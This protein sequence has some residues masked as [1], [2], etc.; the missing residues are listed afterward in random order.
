[1]NNAINPEYADA[2]QKISSML[3]QALWEGEPSLDKKVH[4][5]DSIINKLLH[6]VGL[7]V[8]TM[9]LTELANFVTKKAVVRQ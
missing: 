3:F 9:L 4:E 7:L 6:N 1:M 2:V 5:I 8:E